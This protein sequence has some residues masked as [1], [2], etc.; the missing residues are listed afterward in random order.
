VYVVNHW[1]NLRPLSQ[2]ENLSRADTIHDGRYPAARSESQEGPQSWHDRQNPKAA[3]LP[4]ESMADVVVAE[5][6]SEVSPPLLTWDPNSFAAPPGP[7]TEAAAQLLR[8]PPHTG[9]VFF[10]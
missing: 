9:A 3:H 1:P 10:E 8:D 5:R 6:Q 2:T 4:V 7:L